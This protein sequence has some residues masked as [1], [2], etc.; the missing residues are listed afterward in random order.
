MNRSDL[1]F[2]IPFL[3]CG[4]LPLVISGCKPSTGTAKASSQDDGHN[5]SEGDGHDHGAEEAHA[6]EVVL[7]AAAIEQYGIKDEPAQLWQ[8]R[9]TSVVPARVGFNTEAMAHVGS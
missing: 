9:P 2:V 5:H 4:S 3:L 7:T 1:K 6:D 8:L